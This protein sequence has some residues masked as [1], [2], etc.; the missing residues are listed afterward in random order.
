MS[1]INFILAA[2]HV[3][4]A[5]LIMLLCRPLLR[6]NVGRNSLYG[7]RTRK[8]L[9]SDENWDAINRYGA[10][11]MIRW[12]WALL[13]AG[14]LTLFLPLEGNTPMTL[15]AAVIPTLL[16]IVPCVQTWLYSRKF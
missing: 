6:G 14:V 10:A 3:G 8:S 1:T 7:F 2:S 11:A 4:T 15:L 5:V 13:V 16:V 12:G 9:E